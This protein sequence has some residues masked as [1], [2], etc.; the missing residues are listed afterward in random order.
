MLPDDL[1]LGVGGTALVRTAGVLRARVV[2]PLPARPGG[3]GL[4]RHRPGG[5]PLGAA[6]HLG[7]RRHRGQPVEGLGGHD[8]RLRLLRV[9]AVQLDRHQ[10]Q[11]QPPHLGQLPGERLDRDRSVRE[12]RVGADHDPHQLVLVLGVPAGQ[13]R[14]PDDLLP[15]GFL[16]CP[17]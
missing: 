14:E 6:Q 1:L 5:D 13:V 8:D 11:R 9:R 4:H 10:V 16:S 3:R 7:H 2:D 12:L 17:S 15:H